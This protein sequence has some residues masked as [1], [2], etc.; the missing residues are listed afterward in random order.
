MACVRD[1]ECMDGGAAE[2][3][4][5][6]VRDRYLYR[7]VRFT[8]NIVDDGYG[9]V[10]RRPPGGYREGA[11]GKGIIDTSAG[12]RAARYLVVHRDFVDACSAKRDGNDRVILRRLDSGRSRNSEVYVG[13]RVI[14]LDCV[15]VRR[16]GRFQRS[17]LWVRQ[18]QYYCLVQ[19]EIQFIDNNRG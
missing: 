2:G 9:N 5:C 6:C 10:P 4:V 1:F 18:R 16:R 13:I 15:G 3:R 12:G 7:F 14:V 11:V 19:L 8:P 17:I